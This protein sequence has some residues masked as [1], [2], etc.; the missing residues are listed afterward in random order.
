MPTHR[1][2]RRLCSGA[3][4]ATTALAAAA[5]LFVAGAGVGRPTDGLAAR[6]SPIAVSARQARLDVLAAPCGTRKLDVALENTS[7]RAVYADVLV[8][9]QAPLATS[10]DLISSYLP[11]GYELVVPVEVSAP[12]G[13]T[14]G[15]YEVRI[16]VVGGRLRARAS[17]PVSVRTPPTGPGANLALDAAVVASSS[18]PSYPACGVADGNRNQDDWG[19]STGWND[20]T[21]AVFPDELRAEFPEPRLV[22]RVDLL[23][24]DSS[25]YPVARYGL[26]DWDVQVLESGGWRTVAT[27]RGNRSGLVSSVFTPVRVDAVRILALGSNDGRYSRVMELEIYAE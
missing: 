13:A 19:V 18:N 16:E 3:F 26:R 17:A 5:L 25:R 21:P 1:V 8:S 20:Y 22:G 9:A 24:L 6:T 12:R 15:E 10:R 2:T 11:P 7:A 27:V 23:T 4:A 14:P